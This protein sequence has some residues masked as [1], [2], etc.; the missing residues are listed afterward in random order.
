M[1]T[2]RKDLFSTELTLEGQWPIVLGATLGREAEVNLKE[3]EQ[4]SSI[5]CPKADIFWGFAGYDPSPSSAYYSLNWV[6]FF[7]FFIFVFSRAVP[8]AYGGSQARGLIEAIA[9]SNVGSEPHLR[10]TPQLTAMP[11]PQPTERG[12]R[13]NPQP[14]GSQL[15]SLTIEPRRETPELGFKS[16]STKR[17]VISHVITVAASSIILK[18]WIKNLS[19][20]S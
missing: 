13:S 8:A 1:G 9:A 19:K 2:L 17:S 12:Q 6:L 18:V 3:A 15:D 14:H 11:D 20:G 4:Q 16:F 5:C 10:P 7:Y